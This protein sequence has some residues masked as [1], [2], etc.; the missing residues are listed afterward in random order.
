M[1]GDHYELQL[2]NVNCNDLISSSDKRN[3]HTRQQ[4]TSG[5]TSE[6]QEIESKQ[7]FCGLLCV[8]DYIREI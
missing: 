5:L 3:L 4:E 1:E 8:R 7:I 6:L 2:T